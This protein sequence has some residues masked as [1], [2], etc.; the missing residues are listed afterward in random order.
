MMRKTIFS[1][2]LLTAAVL[3]LCVPCKVLAEEKAVA[4]G[5]SIQKAIDTAKPGDT[6]VVAPGIYKERIVLADKVSVIAKE[7]GKSV[8]DAWGKGPAVLAVKVGAETKLSGFVITGGDHYR[9]GGIHLEKALL[10]IENCV[11]LENKASIGGGLYIHD[12]SPK[13]VGCT[14]EK[15]TAAHGGGAYI[16]N[17]AAKFSRCIFKECSSTKQGGAIDNYRSE[18]T[19]DN[20]L[21]Y[22][23]SALKGGAVCNETGAKLELV[24]CTLT[25]NTAKSGSGVYNINA[26]VTNKAGILWGNG[27]NEIKNTGRYTFTTVYSNISGY[28]GKDGNISADP[29]FADSAKKDFH[30]LA[31][32][33][34]I[35]KGE[36]ALVNH[37]VETDLD[38]T[39]RAADGNGDQLL[40]VDM[41]AYEF[42]PVFIMAKAGSTVEG[43]MAE[44]SGTVSANYAKAPFVME[45]D[46][47]DGVKE[48]VNF[49]AGTVNFVVKHKY[50]D[51]DAKDKPSRDYEVKLSVKDQANRL[52]SVVTKVTVTNV[53]PAVFIPDKSIRLDEAYYYQGSF[54]DPGTDSWTA[55]VDYGESGGFEAVTVASDKTFSL[56]H[57][58][59]ESGQYTVK[60]RISDDDGGVAAASASVNVRKQQSSSG[61]SGSSGSTPSTP[62]LSNNANLAG[63]QLSSGVLNPTFDPSVTSYNVSIAGGINSVTVTPTAAESHAVIRVNGNMVQSGTESEAINIGA[64]ITDITIAVTAQDGTTHKEYTVHISHMPLLLEAAE[65]NEEGTVV[66]LT[67]VKSMTDPAGKHAQFE[68][69]VNDS[70]DTVTSAVYGSSNDKI[71]LLLEKNIEF[72]D[73]VTVS[74]TP[75]DVTAADGSVLEAFEDVA[76]ENKVSGEAPTVPI[77]ISAELTDQGVITLTFDMPMADPSGHESE[78]SANIGSAYASMVLSWNSNDH[79]KIDMH[80][81]EYNGESAYVSLNSTVSYTAGTLASEDG[82]LLESFADVQVT[83]TETPNIVSAVTDTSGENIIVTFDRAMTVL[84]NQQLS[85]TAWVDVNIMNDVVEVTENADPTKLD[86]KLTNKVTEGQTIILNVHGP[87]RSVNGDYGSIFGE[88]P[89]INNVSLD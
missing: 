47:G 32:S 30:L 10:T 33:P 49:P 52:A 60:V 42:Q 54:Q 40:L 7:P 16:N 80:F 86:L 21:L 81:Y 5:Q 83:A 69:M 89:A 72:G 19:L 24:H 73:I 82:V 44:I 4:D 76:V 15:N 27:L 68:I 84:P 36:A 46:W 34:C 48:P 50:L 9:G 20:C 12:G 64:G 38:N 8:I 67:F 56:S 35:D 88:Y 51:D 45:A 71:D 23:N 25:G 2:L 55:S 85:F 39:T 22:G 31:N 78:F 74:Y 43:G 26:A 59:N 18:T 63:L 58:Y 79:R 62:V 11:V 1:I 17:G 70:E 77:L 61:S 29:L 65:T 41:G 66:T 75:G 87:V 13:L 14:F 57:V 28:E 53:S 37:G 3:L 6:L